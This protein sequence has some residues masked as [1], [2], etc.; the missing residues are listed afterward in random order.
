MTNLG[1][2]RHSDESP[3]SLGLRLDVHLHRGRLTH[4][5]ADGVAPDASARHA[6]RARQLTDPISRRR[7]ARSVRRVVSDARDRRSTMFGSA[8]PVS[9]E[10][11]PFTGELEG[12]AGRLEGTDPV[13][14]A[15]AARV[16]LS[17]T[18]GTSPIYDPQ[19]SSTVAQTMK[20][21]ADGFAT[22]GADGQGD[23]LSEPALQQ[24]A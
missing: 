6:L 4:D 5:L 8:V 3:S 12:V 18:D 24:A 22:P 14:A 1:F 16:L 21:I 2:T 9:R 11:L 13:S 10:V 17:L 7:L 20:W 19:P 23:L 15:A